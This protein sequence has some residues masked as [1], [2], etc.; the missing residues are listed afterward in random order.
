MTA[1]TLSA[2]D[3]FKPTNNTPTPEAPEADWVAFGAALLQVEGVKNL[4]STAL[5]AEE[6]APIA[7]TL[8]AGLVEC[9]KGIYGTFDMVW[10]LA[11]SAG[12]VSPELSAEIREVA[13]GFNIPA[14]FVLGL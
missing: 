4:L 9:S 1:V 10:G 14:P 13:Q 7:L 6:T 2:S 8:P 5:Q 3:R 12:L 11:K